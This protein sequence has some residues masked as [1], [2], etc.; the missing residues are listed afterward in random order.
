MAQALDE[1]KANEF[2][3]PHYIIYN[4]N[5]L[6]NISIRRSTVV[7]ANDSI[8]IKLIFPVGQTIHSMT[9]LAS[10]EVFFQKIAH[11]NRL[12]PKIYTDG[13]FNKNKPSILPFTGYSYINEPIDFT[14]SFYYICMEFYGKSKGWLGPVYIY[15]RQLLLGKSNAE[16]FASFLCKL[17]YTAKIA[18]I[19]DPHQHFYYN[20]FLGELK[21]IDYAECIEC[22]SLDEQDICMIKMA[23]LIGLDIEDKKVAEI[24]TQYKRK[25]TLRPRNNTR[26][27]HSIQSYQAKRSQSRSPHKRSQSRSPHKRSQSRNK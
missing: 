25:L 17:I 18:N 1:V 16:L 8:A 27:V 23:E 2:T 6:A 22:K 14:E 12:G 7:Y 3:Y 4:G 10:D 21:M 9:K 5:Q 13:L 19:S 24:I 11:K 26:R 15:T 20:S